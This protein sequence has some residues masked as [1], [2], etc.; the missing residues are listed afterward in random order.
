MMLDDILPFELEREAGPPPA[1]PADFG[2]GY[3]LPTHTEK[4]LQRL[5]PHPIDAR[6]VFYEQ[7]HI[8]TLDGVPTSL[9]VTGLA[10][11]CEEGFDPDKGISMMRSSRS[12]AWPRLDYVHNAR[13]IDDVVEWSNDFGLLSVNADGKTMAALPPRSMS[14]GASREDALVV[15]ET[16][17]IK[18][19]RDLTDRIYAFDAVLTDDEIKEKWRAN[20]ERASHMGTEAHYLA[21]C[22]FNGVPFRWWEPDVQILYDFCRTYL[23]PRGIVGYRTEWEIVCKD[24]DL[25]GSID[26]LVKQDDTLHIIDHKRSDKLQDSLR[27]YSKMKAPL[28]HLDDCKG[29]AYALQLSIYQYILERD[30]G[31]KIGDRI[32]LSL[33]ADKPF[34][35]AVPYLREEVDYLMTERFRLVKARRRVAMAG[36]APVEFRC[37]LSGAPTVDAVKVEEGYAMERAAIVRGK[38]FEVAQ[39]VRDRFDRAVANAM[40]DEPALPVDKVPWWKRMPKQGLRPF[41]NV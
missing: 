34:S 16:S 7:P 25:S 6:H 9:S 12:Q 1:P 23:V 38:P 17:R 10:H 14:A 31:V 8:Y 4:P 28:D 27:G 33:H 36:D 35:T 15:L 3:V 2:A 21:E 32:L 19:K 40:R 30:Y 5:N 39:D 41:S 18:G 26:L 22:F 24:A 29:A 20:G 37:V 13:D 11:S